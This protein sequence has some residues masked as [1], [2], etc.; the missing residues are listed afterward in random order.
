MLIGAAH[1]QP[2]VVHRRWSWAVRVRAQWGIAVRLFSDAAGITDGLWEVEGRYHQ[3]PANDLLD[4][5]VAYKKLGGADAAAIPLG[6]FRCTGPVADHIEFARAKVHLVGRSRE[7][8][9]REM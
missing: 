9:F 4:N 5:R 1:R 2:T 7:G 8:V 6:H 3:P